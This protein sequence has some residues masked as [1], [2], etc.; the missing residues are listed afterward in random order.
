MQAL[1]STD[2][3]FGKVKERGGENS[4]HRGPQKTDCQGNQQGFPMFSL[5]LRNLGSQLRCRFQ[6]DTLVAEVAQKSA[7]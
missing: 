1:K 2:N 3:V 6:N 4:G 5:L 7:E